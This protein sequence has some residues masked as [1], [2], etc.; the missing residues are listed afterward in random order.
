MYVYN[1]LRGNFFILTTFFGHFKQVNVKCHQDVIADSCLTK[2]CWFLNQ[3]IGSNHFFETPDI[4]E[5]YKIY[6]KRAK[7]TNQCAWKE[8][9]VLLEKTLLVFRLWSPSLFLICIC[10]PL[11]FPDFISKVIVIAMSKLFS[12]QTTVARFLALVTTMV[13]KVDHGN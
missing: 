4:S 9:F 12:E 2:K 5:V 8:E 11:L 6:A 3:E 1:N 7:Q 10:K 13:T